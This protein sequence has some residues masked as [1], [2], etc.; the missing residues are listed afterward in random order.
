MAVLIISN[1]LDA[2]AD[3]VE[4]RILQL[5][6]ETIRFDTDR[7]ITDQVELIFR[8]S[9]NEEGI[10][11]GGKWNSFNKISSILLRRPGCPETKIEEPYQKK[12]AETEAEE[13]IRQLY[14]Y[15]REIFWVS[16][17]EALERARRKILQL[18][19]ARS[20]GFKIP[21][22][23]VTNSPKEIKEFFSSNKQT[24]YKTLKSP[25]IRL[26]EETELWGVP[27]TVVNQKHMASIDLIKNTGGIFQEYVEKKY[28]IR[29]TIIGKKLFAAKIDSQAE[30]SARIDWREAEA[31]GLVK[32][33]PY[34]LPSLVEDQCRKIVQWYGL[35]FGAIDLIYTPGGEY[36]FL[37]LNCNG[38]WLWVE[39]ITG[40]P[41]L[42]CMAN[43]LVYKHKNLH[44]LSKKRR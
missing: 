18:Q 35:N 9:G 28:E 27:T 23:L 11:I 12:F 36:V 6:T 25:V 21:K 15:L 13:F 43:L 24:I 32:V 38:Q 20:L 39:E 1:S 22:T 4:K 34:K 40:Q 19:V 2:H 31:L 7:F 44:I 16:N 30:P 33:V 3:I 26:G 10:N 41:L 42:D 5:G 14:F 8:D 29:V 17:I 37:E